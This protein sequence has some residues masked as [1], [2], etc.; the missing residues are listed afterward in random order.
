MNE[1]T[2]KDVPGFPGY[3]VGDDGSVWSCRTKARPGI[4]STWHRVV[5]TLRPKQRYRTVCF[6]IGPQ[7]YVRYVHRLVLEAFVGP[8]PEGMQCCHK[9]GDPTDNRLENLRWDTASAN[10]L[11]KRKH[12]TMLRGESHPYAKLTE[13]D[14][15]AIRSLHTAGVPSDVIGEAFQVS[16]CYVNDVARGESWSHVPAGDFDEPSNG[17]DVPA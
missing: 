12:G 16:D 8:C 14:V 9:N 7:N 5:G 17:Q 10:H 11:D 4:S 13:K 6:R 3:R 1:V 15:V 2:Y